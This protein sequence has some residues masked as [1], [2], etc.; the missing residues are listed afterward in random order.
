MKC[1]GEN[2]QTE[3]K[4]LKLWDEEIKD[5]EKRNQVYLFEQQR[6]MR[7]VTKIQNN[8]NY[9]QKKTS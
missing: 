6:I 4:D 2:Q 1:Q 7:S 8:Q 3:G 9:S 5:T